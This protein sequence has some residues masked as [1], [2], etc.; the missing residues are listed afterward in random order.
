MSTVLPFT[1][2]VGHD[3]VRTA[4]LVAAV[5]AGVGGV[6]LTGEKGTAKTTLVRGFASVL[7]EISVLS[8]CRFSCH[9]VNPDPSC[10]DGPHAPGGAWESRPVR[11]VELPLGATDDRVTGSMDVAKVLAGASIS[12][13]Y[14]PG[15]LAA[16][17]RGIL[18]VDEINLLPDA[19]VDLLLDAA[20]TGRVIVER[21]GI[22][23]AHPAQFILVGTMNPEE[24]ELRP[25]LLDRFG[26]CVPVV[27]SQDPQQRIA[28]VRARLGFDS[29]PGAVVEQHAQRLHA[30]SNEIAV[31]RA[32]LPEVDLPEAELLRITNACLALGVDGLRGDIVTARAAR[33]LAAWRGKRAVDATDVADAARLTLPH[34]KRRGPFDAPGIDE[35]E[36]QDA[37][38]GPDEPEPDND[39]DGPGGGAPEQDGAAKTSGNEISQ[40][41]NHSTSASE[42]STPS[43]APA[44]AS[45]E[46]ERTPQAGAA[47]PTASLSLEGAT[48]PTRRTSLR[49][50]AVGEAGRHARGPSDRGRATGSTP[51]RDGFELLATLRAAAPFQTSRGRT[52]DSP[53][54]LVPDDLRASIRD[55]RQASLVV[56]LLDA[57]GSM[58]ARERVSTVSTLVRSMLHDTYC[59]R[60]RVAVV[61]MSKGEARIAVPATGSNDLAARALHGLPVGGRTA[62]A[63]G[64]E[65]TRQLCV[66]ERRRDPMRQQLVVVITDGR[67]TAGADAVARS[68]RAA[69]A[70]G[71]EAQCMLIDAEQGMVRLGLARELAHLMGTEAVPLAGLTAHADLDRTAAA[72]QLHELVRTRK[73]A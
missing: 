65:L 15:L 60:D 36:L 4:L 32:Q 34:R 44:S 49:R 3:D 54:R 70:L 19:L 67:A 55:G 22:S 7:P 30:L 69:S 68:R 14:T 17:H 31:A 25:Q 16:A 38:G 13:S 42:D 18:Y 28:A 46:Q 47:A 66:R 50:T 61:A 43:E 63:E 58:A 62:L 26:L 73:V 11:L 39:P 1:A 5:D 12:E 48:S 72:A 21:D 24:G 40:Q 57:S 33:S 45:A 10:P 41:D 56:L 37:L 20:A 29:D 51:V 2:V 64:L 52:S 6:L 59:R 8:D 23:V 53:L 35:Q 71:T 27:A 9:P